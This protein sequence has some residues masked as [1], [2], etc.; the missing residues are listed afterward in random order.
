MFRSTMMALWLF[1][2]R[3]DL[4]FIGL[5]SDPCVGIFIAVMRSV[6]RNMEYWLSVPRSGTPCTSHQA[7]GEGGKHFCPLHLGIG[8]ARK[9]TGWKNTFLTRRRNRIIAASV[10]GVGPQGHQ[11]SPRRQWGGGACMAMHT[12][13]LGLKNPNPSFMESE[14][15]RLGASLGD[16]LI[17][18]Q[19]EQRKIHWPWNREIYFHRRQ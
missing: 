13:F 1:L 11:G 17:Y 14:I 8:V 9:D 18:R 2:K 5:F 10:V 15:W 12:P 3:E 4:V 7:P 6:Q 19:A 16:P